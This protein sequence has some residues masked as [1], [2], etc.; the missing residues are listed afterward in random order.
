MMLRGA[1]IGLGNIAIRGHLPAF[2]KDEVLQS[3]MKIVAAMDIVASGENSVKEHLPEARFY[4]DLQSLLRNE[5]L[6]FVDICSPPHTH[7]DCIH[8]CASKGHHILCEKPLTESYTTSTGTAGVVRSSNVVFVP[9]HQYKYS[10]LWK[11]IHEK[12]REGALGRVT[13]AQF[14]VFRLQADTGTKTWNPAWRTEQKHS[15]GGILV[16]TGAHYFYL[17][18]YFFGMPAGVHAILRTLKH[19]DYAVEDTAVVTLEYPEMLMEIN[20]TWAAAQRANSV[21]IVGTEGMLSYNGSSLVLS[22][23]HG[24]RELP[25]PNV[26]DKQQYI[27][28][29]ASLFKEFLRRVE[30]RDCSDDL[31]CEAVNVMKLLDLSYQSSQG[32]NVTPM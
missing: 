10:P 2:L 7:A 30:T 6:D 28:W 20:L 14:N 9:C 1:L 22:D 27:G 15:G 19:K 12:I 25:M 16:D 32:H 23:A 29:Y 3:K 8:A 21:L 5:Q 11:S 17:A 4:D 18:Q 31:L 13:F 26:S 24:S